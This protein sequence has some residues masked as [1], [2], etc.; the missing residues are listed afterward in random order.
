[1]TKYF[2]LL[3]LLLGWLAPLHILPWISWHNELWSFVAMIVLAW[4][5]LYTLIKRKD[6]SALG[7]PFATLPILALGVIAA[8]QTAAGLINFAGDALVLG[9]YLALCV[10][11]LSLGF[12]Y[13]K[14]TLPARAGF[15]TAGSVQG[16]TNIPLLAF[17]LLIAA[18]ISTVLAL[19]QIF[20]LWADANWIARMPALRRPGANLGQ[21]NQ[22]AS[23]VLMGIGSLLFLYES[24]KLTTLPATLLLF[25]L[26]IGLAATESRTGLLS[27]CLLALWFFAKRRAIGFRLSAWVVVLS[28]LCV[29]GLFWTWPALIN[30]IQLMGSGA[31]VS[32][33]PGMRLIVWP[34]L[35][36]ALALRPWWGWGIGRISAAHNAVVDAYPVSEPFTYSH[37]ILLDLG[38]GVGVP[39][40]ALLVLLGAVWLWR[41]VTS[42]Q[43]LLPWYCLAVALPLAVHS[44][45]EFPFAY[46]YFLVPVM[47]LLGVLEG[48]LAPNGFVRIGW[49]PVAMG[50]FLV[51][52]TMAWSAVEYIAIEEDFRIARFEAMHI[53]RTP[54]SY[55]RPKIILLTQ[56]GALLEGSRTV[57]APGMS[58]ERID[59]ARKLALHFPSPALQN[60]YALSLALNGNPEEAIRQLKVMRAM[61][62]EKAYQDIKANWSQLADTRYAQLKLLKIP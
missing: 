17:A 34:Q 62:G 47:F 53:G 41:R 16:N 35:L 50:L 39:V 3:C 52:V 48:A 23:L 42:T 37:N 21:P 59:L 27:F 10:I 9:F 32:T 15:E 60:R 8:I 38:L 29:F 55:K 1:M 58:R 22:L 33:Q 2:A 25:I 46:A 61:H 13:Q 56:L 28:M 31:T 26:C 6:F 18:F 54:N 14:R 5:G 57:P 7:L 44:M 43:Q 49:W 40:A 30:A 12:A 4:S 19:A 45:L 51:T 20:D 36:A 24:R 11:C